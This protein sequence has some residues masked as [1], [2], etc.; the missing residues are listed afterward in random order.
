MKAHLSKTVVS[1]FVSAMSRRFPLFSP[2]SQGGDLLSLKVGPELFFFV[3]LSID[4]DRDAFTLEVASNIVNQ[5]PWAELPGQVRDV[6]PAARRDVWRFRIAK[7]WG[8]IKDLR[9]HVGQTDLSDARAQIEDAVDK[10][11]R[12]ASPFFEQVALNHGH[13]LLWTRIN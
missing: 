6:E 4:E 2:V 3:H 10:L 8:E 11:C 12:Y 7:L 9:W 1:Y 13:K 5:F